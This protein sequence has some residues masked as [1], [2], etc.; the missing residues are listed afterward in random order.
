MN[1][2]NP[3]YSTPLSSPPVGSKYKTCPKDDFLSLK[4]TLH[5]LC[6]NGSLVIRQMPMHLGHSSLPLSF[7]LFAAYANTEKNKVLNYDTE[8]EYGQMKLKHKFNLKS[9]DRDNVSGSNKRK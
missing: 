7:L 3:Q 1:T 2:P 8:N 9:V 6:Y 4:S 5:F